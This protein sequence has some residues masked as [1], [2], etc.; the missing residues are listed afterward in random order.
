[1]RLSLFIKIR[2][3]P[4]PKSIINEN[5]YSITCRRTLL[6]FHK[7]NYQENYRGNL[8]NS[9]TKTELLLFQRE[10]DA[11]DVI[12]IMELSQGKINRFIRDITVTNGTNTMLENIQDLDIFGEH[13]DSLK[14]LNIEIIPYN[15]FEKLCILHFFDMLI[16]YN[17]NI[18]NIKHDQ[19]EIFMDCYE[20]KTIEYP[21]RIIQE[22]IFR[23]MLYL[24]GG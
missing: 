14:P 15:Y 6:G 20:Y 16:V 3:T 10:N 21:N 18:K 7:M 17:Q 23:D 8:D 2:N 24:N 9:C 19:Y 13:A 12:K 4:I 5:L 1:M 11:K 22:K